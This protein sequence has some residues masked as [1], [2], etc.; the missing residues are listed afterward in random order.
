LKG[1]SNPYE[2]GT[3]KMKKIILAAG[4]FLASFTSVASTDPLGDFINQLPQTNHTGLPLQFATVINKAPSNSPEY[5]AALDNI[6]P[7]QK[8]VLE[9]SFRVGN[10]YE[11]HTAQPADTEDTRKLGYHLAAI[12]WIESRA[13]ENVGKGKKNHHA[14]GCWQVTYSSAKN[15]L[16]KQYPKKAVVAKLETLRGGSEFAIYELQYWLNYHKGD[17]KKALAS[18]NAGFK[19]RK[20]EARQYAAMVTHTAKLLEQKRIL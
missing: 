4:I 5:V 14:Y 12:A 8:K 10:Q 6:T 7:S 17:V 11:L 1:R 3:S 18:Y 9:Y 13:C 2:T 19:Y 20:G 16:D 15:R